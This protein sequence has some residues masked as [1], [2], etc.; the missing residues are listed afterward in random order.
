MKISEMTR[1]ELREYM[2]SNGELLRCS[3][4]SRAWQRAFE[5]ARAAGYGKLDMDC[6]K[7]WD[8]VTRFIRGEKN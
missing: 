4:E 6:M 2:A 3:S 1:E 5:L 7:C 8:K